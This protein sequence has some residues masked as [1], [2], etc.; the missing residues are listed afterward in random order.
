MWDCNSHMAGKHQHKHSLVFTADVR[1][2]QFSW[3]LLLNVV[4]MVNLFGVSMPALRTGPKNVFILNKC[5][6]FFS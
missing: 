6:I 3:I 2:I 1:L 5:H 4:T